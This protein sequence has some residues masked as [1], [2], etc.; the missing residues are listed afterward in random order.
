MNKSEQ[1]IRDYWND[2]ARKALVGKT[3]KEARYM[4][5]DEA[6]KWGW[7]ERSIVLFFDDGSWAIPQRDD[8]GNGGGALSI[9]GEPQVLPVL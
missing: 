5:Q 6:D 7:Y 9:S 2:L 8:E 1:E 3:I 4:T